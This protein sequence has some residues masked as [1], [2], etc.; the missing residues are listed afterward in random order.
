MSVIFDLLYVVA[1]FIVLIY[2]AQKFVDGASGLALCLGVPEI[3]I[4]ILIIGF[5]TSAPE[6][7]VSVFSALDN[8]P[9]LA[10]GNA[11]GSNICNIALVLGFTALICPVL[12]K[13]SLQKKEFPLLLLT[14]LVPLFFAWD[15]RISQ[16]ESAILLV[17]ISLFVMYTVYEGLRARKLS[18][19]AQAAE[20]ESDVQI[21]EC[22][23]EARALG[24]LKSSL[25]T[26]FGLL[27]MVLSSKLIVYGAVGIAH[28]L[29]ISEVVIGLTVVAVGT[30][31]PELTASV[32]A[33]RKGSNE[34]ALG[35]IIGSNIFNNTAV[36]GLA[37][38]I[39]P[40]DVDS[41]V[42]YRDG[43]FCLILTLSLIIF[44]LN[45]K[46]GEATLG[47]KSG[48]FWVSLYVMYV[49]LLVYMTLNNNRL[50]GIL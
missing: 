27:F 38:V 29:E 7:L 32:V 35:N 14:V 37:G 39:M 49:M 34:L 19:S 16:G 46:S 5:G 25:Y 1:G 44:S 43:G 18:K 28:V 15:G 20:E 31:L 3:L 13:R 45:L 42:L 21:E 8:S 6:M 12:V 41:I 11:W 40:Y 50:P 26:L 4:G 30:S 33:A 2:S 22:S 24:P 17:F 23:A 36:L 47:R 9:A 10:L 48:L